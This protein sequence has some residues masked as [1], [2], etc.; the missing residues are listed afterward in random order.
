ME[1]ANSFFNLG[2][3]D[4]LSY[5]KSF[6]HRLDPRIKTIVTLTF[7]VT[8]VSFPQKE[9]SGLLSF[10]IYP[11][12]II[13]LAEIPLGFI[14]KKLV[15]VSPFV[16]M[17]AIFNP[18]LDKTPVMEL[19]GITIT[20][21]WISFLSIIV[22]F[23]L[24]ISAALLLI[25][26]TSFVGICEGLS[27]M[28]VPEVFVVQLMLLYRYIFVLVEEAL[29]MVRARDSRSFGKKGRG[30]KT[31]INLAGILLVRTIHRADRIYS[32]MLS[33]GYS[34]TI[35]QKRTHRI[36]TKEV[37]YLIIW[38]GLFILFRKY[39]LSLAIGQLF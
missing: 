39:N 1:I 33:R 37:F 32:A 26:T 15:I 23:I 20:T 10:F 12:F 22:K 18:F 3:L 34:G 29:R 36:R 35:P 8:V 11:V 30:I 24:T 4:S 21:G 25:A 31:F 14:L 16:L 17:V 38:V 19:Y 9:L 27:R 5:K 7:V 13:A 2:Y 28:R 6:I